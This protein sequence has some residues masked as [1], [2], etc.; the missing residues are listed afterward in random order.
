MP[1][2]IIEKIFGPSESLTQLQ[3]ANCWSRKEKISLKEGDWLTIP[4]DEEDIKEVV[5]S[6]EKNTAPGPDNMPI[7]FFQSCLAFYKE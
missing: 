2:T 7:K 1:L 5:F 6:M 4:F 3:D